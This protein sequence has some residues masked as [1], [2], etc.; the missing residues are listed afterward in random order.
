M[1]PA[2]PSWSAFTK[3]ADTIVLLPAAAICAAWLLMRAPRLAAAW[4]GLLGAGLALV[5]ASKIAFAAWGLGIREWNFI[6]F[7]GHAMRA[8][9]IAPVLLYLLALPAS[10]LVRTVA[11][12]AGFGFGILIAVSR[13]VL[14]V[15]SV[16]EV[17]SGC[18]LGMLVS[19]SFLWLL[20]RSPRL[21]TAWH[22]LLPVLLPLLLLPGAPPA[23]TE[24]WIDAVATRLSGRQTPYTRAELGYAELRACRRPECIESDIPGKAER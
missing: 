12:I 24:R 15:H 8:A 23:P 3:V 19:L 4:I 10:R 17:V 11:L 13:V 14:Q 9:A 7:S 18:L 20:A 16:S 6:G 22:T 2:T 5:A 1:I 21:K